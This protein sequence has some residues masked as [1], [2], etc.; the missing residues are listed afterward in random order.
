MGAKRNA[1][2]TTVSFTGS[3][4]LMMK[5][6]SNLMLSRGRTRTWLMRS[7]IFLTNWVM[8]VGPSMSWTNN[9]VVWRLRRRNFKLPLRKLKQHWNKKRTK[10]LG[11]NLSLDRFVK[12]LIDA[13]KRKR[14][15]L[16]TLARTINALWTLWEHLL[17]L[18]SMSL[19]LPLTMLTKLMLKAKRLSSATKDNFVIP[20]KA[21]KNKQE[22]VKRSK[23]LLAL[24]AQGQCSFR[25]G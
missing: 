16:I 18:T 19:K 9:V 15:S 3:R 4:L 25:R 13:S 6:L 24:R 11:L 14:R 5:L 8:V 7:R 21:M 20:S 1:V 10:F 2:T 22:A 12:R 17:N 23:K